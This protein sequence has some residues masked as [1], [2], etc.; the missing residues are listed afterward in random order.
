MLVS[1]G[2]AHHISPKS[3]FYDAR[4]VSYMAEFDRNSFGRTD[5]GA[6][7]QAVIDQGLRAYM[8]RVYNYMSIG[9]MITGLAALGVAM[10]AVTSD[11]TTGVAQ[12][13]EGVFLTQFGALVYTSPLKWVIMFAPLAVVFLFSAKL[14]TMSVGTAQTVFWLFSALMGVSISWILLVFTGES[15][16]RVFFI[17]AAAFGG[18]SIW[19]YVT[20]K[21]LSGWGSFLIMGL[22]GIIIASIVNIFLASSALQFAISVIGVLIFAGLTAYDTQRIKLMYSAADSAQV[23]GQK[24]ISGA[25]SL[26]LNF[27]NMFMML[28]QLF[29]NR[30]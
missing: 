4:K 20:Q 25:L 27:I 23:A 6:R 12:F 11:P 13:R 3:N 26:Y 22:I 18:L 29:G 28:L 30:E 17:T 19:G 2:K 14:H 16:V 10:L 15:V 1:G 24:A 7:S 5:V 8:L 21:N 9:L